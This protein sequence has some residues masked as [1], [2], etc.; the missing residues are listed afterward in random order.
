MFSLGA[1][2]TLL[3]GEKVIPFFDKKWFSQDVFI[4]VLTIPITMFYYN[5]FLRET[6]L[7]RSTK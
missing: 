2:S 3:A 6:A 7:K 4:I 5:H 1:L